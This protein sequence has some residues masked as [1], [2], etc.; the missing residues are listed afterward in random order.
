M[1]TS[2]GAIGRP[3]RSG[4]RAGPSSGCR[5]FAEN[6]PDLANH[7]GMILAEVA[8]RD[9]LLGDDTR[10]V[11][12]V[13]GHETVRPIS[14]GRAGTNRNDGVDLHRG[15]RRKLVKAGQDRRSPFQLVNAGRHGLTEMFPE[16]C[17]RVA[18]HQPVMGGHQRV[19][20]TDQPRAESLDRA[21]VEMAAPV[22]RGDVDHPADLRPGRE[23]EAAAKEVDIRLLAHEFA[24]QAGR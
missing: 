2:L 19:R 5:V 15:G 10:D 9:D 4:P 8:G 21:P 18:R 23:E 20:N 3:T 11:G 7:V 13:V 22:R 6:P 14:G 12:A 24:A 16:E 17:R 1:T